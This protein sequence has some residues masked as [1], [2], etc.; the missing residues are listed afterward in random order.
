MRHHFDSCFCNCGCYIFVRLLENLC[1]VEKISGCVN[2]ETITIFN[3]M[4]ITFQVFYYGKLCI[5]DDS[6]FSK[7]TQENSK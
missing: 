3:S 4:L 2:R 7:H 5:K 6:S 1:Y